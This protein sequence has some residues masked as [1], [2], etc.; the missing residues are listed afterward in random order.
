MSPRDLPFSP[1]LWDHHIQPSP[2]HCSVWLFESGAHDA[3]L[4]SL[5]LVIWTSAHFCPP[6][7]GMRG[8]CHTSPF[9]MGL[10]DQTQLFMLC[11]AITLQQK[12]SPQPLSSCFPSFSS[13]SISFTPPGSPTKKSRVLALFTADTSQVRSETQ[14][15]ASQ[16]RLG[17]Q[18]SP[19][20]P[21]PVL[22]APL[23][24]LISLLPWWKEMFPEDEDCV[25]TILLCFYSTLHMTGVQ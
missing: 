6:S 2:C 3:T 13:P 14:T 25:L 16:E 23:P 17:T 7:P 11:E 9:F 22:P 5:E 15:H 24:L 18:M 19:S 10:G 1:Q 20:S 12:P 21:G 8:V 4:E